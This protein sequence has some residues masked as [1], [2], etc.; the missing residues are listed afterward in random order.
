MRTRSLF[1]FLLVLALATGSAS[2]VVAAEEAPAEP[3]VATLE[4]EATEE[5]TPE[6]DTTEAAP[7]ADPFLD[8]SLITVTPMSKI[9]CP[10]QVGVSCCGDPGV[11]FECGNRR[12]CV[13]NGLDE[14]VLQHVHPPK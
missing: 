9:Y 3:E 11:D 1:A 5:V 8:Q 6:S 7:A 10:C 4:S 13:C 2:A 14:C 12:Y